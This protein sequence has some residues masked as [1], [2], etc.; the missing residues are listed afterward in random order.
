MKTAAKAV[1]FLIAVFISAVLVFKFSYKM[2]PEDF[3][4]DKTT[5]IYSNKNIDKE[6]LEKF[7]T[8]FNIK[9][10]KEKNILEKVESIY[11][12]SQSK[13]Y[14]S[15][16]NV[17]GIVD[18]GNCYPLMY[19]K[20]KKYFDYGQDYFYKL[21]SEYKRELGF[22][23]L[24]EVYLK[25]YRGLFFFGT[26][27]ESINRIIYSN[28]A[29]SNKTVKIIDKRADAGLGTLVF[30]QERER[31]FGVDR[32]VISGDIVGNKIVLDGFI[33]GDNEFIKDLNVQP[34]ERRMNKYI[35][36]DRLYISTANLKKMDTFILRAISS[37]ANS[38]KKVRLIQEL[39]TRGFSDVFSELNGEMIIDLQEGNYLLGLKTS[40]NTE[41]FVEYFKNDEDI[42]IEKDIEGNIYI[43]IGDDTFVPV[44][45]RKVIEPNQFLSGKINT[46]YGDVEFDGFYEPE[47]LR[48][49]AQIELN[50]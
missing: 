45:K 44:E 21:K 25:A 20:I 47:R 10:V 30:N 22:T 8:I 27:M 32:V 2:I 1:I 11:F 9:N 17:V 46:H 18:T 41:A 35:T 23:A 15:K 29:S 34:A 31:L 3:I 19:M 43:C 13:V 39:F 16:I 48:I 14:S 24:Q 5:F 50:K 40:D 33:Y 12:L 7:E 26:D 4:T 36:D 6:K 28:A 49:K 42:N 38:T 37:K